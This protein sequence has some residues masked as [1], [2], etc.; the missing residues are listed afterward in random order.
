MTLAENF[1]TFPVGLGLNWIVLL[2]RFSSVKLSLLVVITAQSGA[3]KSKAGSSV[4][5]FEEEFDL[6]ILSLKRL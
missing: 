5:P 6:L 4:S 1:V 3:E 2:V